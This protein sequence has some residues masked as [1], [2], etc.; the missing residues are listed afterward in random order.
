MAPFVSARVRPEPHAAPSSGTTVVLFAPYARVLGTAE[1]RRGGDSLP[2]RAV[3]RHVG[4]TTGGEN[5][6]RSLPSPTSLLG[7]GLGLGLGFGFQSN[8]NHLIL[9]FYSVFYPNLLDLHT[10]NLV[11]IPLIDL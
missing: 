10:R 7:L 6:G 4:G 2:A 1:R 3:F 8:L 5:P 9:D 11:L